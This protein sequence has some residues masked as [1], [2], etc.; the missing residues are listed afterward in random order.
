MP[1]PDSPIYSTLYWGIFL[2]LFPTFP[3]SRFWHKTPSTLIIRHL[4]KFIDFWQGLL[5]VNV[6]MWACRVVTLVP[7]LIV[8]WFAKDPTQALVIGQVVLSIGIPFAVIPLM[9]YTH[10]KELM[11]EWV[12]GTVKHVIFMI[13]VALIVALNV[14]LIVLTI[15]GRA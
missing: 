15:F 10:T 7:A 1:H 13:V 4:T 12:D 14:L 11:G 6:P 2:H 9:R 3:T 8:L 5:H